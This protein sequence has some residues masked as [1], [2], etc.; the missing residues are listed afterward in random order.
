M[1]TRIPY[2]ITRYDNRETANGDI[3]NGEKLNS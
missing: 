2:H 3:G 1:A